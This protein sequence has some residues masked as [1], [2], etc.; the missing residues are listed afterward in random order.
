MH[1]GRQEADDLFW[2]LSTTYWEESNARVNSCIHLRNPFC[3]HKHTISLLCQPQ[4][5]SLV[6]SPDEKAVKNYSISICE[7]LKQPLKC[8]STSVSNQV[9]LWFALLHSALLIHCSPKVSLRTR[10]IY[11]SQQHCCS[12]AIFLLLPEY[13][14]TFPLPKARLV[15]WLVS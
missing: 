15:G 14:S 1:L 10:T 12:C 2:V 9:Q 5:P 11:V 6:G 7:A 3:T 4:Q 8:E 13:N